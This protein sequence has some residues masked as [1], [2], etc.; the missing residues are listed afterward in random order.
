M[1]VLEHIE[2]PVVFLQQQKDQLSPSGKLI[3]GVP[4]C[5]P[6]LKTGDISIFI[7]EHYLYFTQKGIFTLLEK[8]GLF[9][10]GLKW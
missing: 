8:A 1:L 2:D 3:F 5:E 10:E 6:F 4:N 9:L 7:H